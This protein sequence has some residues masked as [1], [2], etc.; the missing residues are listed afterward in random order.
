MPP[1][2]DTMDG[3]VVTAARR[4]LEKGN[5]D[6]VVPWAPKEAEAEIR[7][8]FDKAMAARRLGKEARDT[9]YLWFFETV[10][11]LHRA[12]EGAPYTGLK[13]AGL[14][15]GP[16]LPLAEEALE[17]GSAKKLVDFLSK[18]IAEKVND[19]LKHALKKR[20]DEGKG[21]DAAREAVKATLGLELWSHHLYK[22][23]E[24]ADEHGK[25]S[26]NKH[27]EE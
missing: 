3:P 2:C 8:A 26:D 13:P 4:A 20:K 14:S 27:H 19:K 6:L 17:T 7:K 5:V 9:A 23:I 10:V 15:E 25:E 24:G 1:H 21:V 12:G 11:R 18:T 16:V 22:Y